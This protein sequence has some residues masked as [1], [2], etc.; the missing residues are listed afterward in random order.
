MSWIL[1]CFLLALSLSIPEEVK[2]LSEESWKQVDEEAAAFLKGLYDDAQSKNPVKCKKC[3]S[4][5][6]SSQLQSY[7]L[8]VFISFSVPLESWK[9]WSESLEKTGGIFVIRGLPGNSFRLFSEKVMELKKAGVNAP[10]S[11]DPELY[12]E[13][14]VKAVPTV[15]RVKGEEY[16][17]I[18]GNVH[19]EAAL[20]IFAGD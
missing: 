11:I 7:K 1:P 6:E 2:Q 17:K 4:S 20:K 8:M 5:P 10:I 9:D 3:T 12:E 13:Y 15:V 14:E 19:L 16:D 18:S